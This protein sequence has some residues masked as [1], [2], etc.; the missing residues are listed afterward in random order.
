MRIKLNMP[1]R[2]I[3]NQIVL[4]QNKF[5]WNESYLS[6]PVGVREGQIWESPLS[7]DKIPRCS[8]VI[9]PRDNP[10]DRV[11]NH[12]H[13]NGLRNV[14]SVKKI[15]SKDPFRS[16]LLFFSLQDRKSSILQ[17]ELHLVAVTA[18][19]ENCYQQWVL[20]LKAFLNVV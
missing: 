13:V 17:W 4:F 6:Q 11:S 9:V 7:F 1:F 10:L 19:L 3:W 15:I 20:P 2:G 14:K 12:V 8:Y 16:A 5:E 18:C